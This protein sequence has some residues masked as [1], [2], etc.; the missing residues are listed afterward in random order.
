MHG[1]EHR[2]LGRKTDLDEYLPVLWLIITEYGYLANPPIENRV[3]EV[4]GSTPPLIRTLPLPLALT[5]TEHSPNPVPNPNH[6]QVY[7]NAKEFWVPPL[8]IRVRV[9]GYHPSPLEAGL[10]GT[11]HPHWN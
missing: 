9:M 7:Q 1:D 11:T 4:V 2:G 6:L 3:C 10:G 8:P 5:L